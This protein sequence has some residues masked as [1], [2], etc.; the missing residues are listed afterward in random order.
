MGSSDSQVRPP[1]EKNPTPLAYL[2]KKVLET[3]SVPGRTRAV[4]LCTGSLNPVHV[5]HLKVFDIAA[6]LLK[7]QYSVDCLVGFLSPSS[8]LYVQDKLGVNAL[9]FRDRH[10]MCVLSCQE[11]NADPNL[12]HVEC[13]SWEGL[14]PDFYDFPTVRE[15]MRSFIDEQFPN[16]GIV[17]LYVC[18]SDHFVRCRLY[19]WFDCVAI[20]RPSHPMTTESDPARGLYLFQVSDEGYADLFGTASSTEVRRRIANK[21]PLDG[22]VYPSVAKYLAKIRYA[23]QTCDI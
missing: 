11:H 4:L 10:H 5:T 20:G 3:P 8:D 12:L 18:G 7:E 16:S 1:D 9:S 6:K 19:G 17:V 13:D 15:R 14:Q 2:R 21:E 23:P 22:I